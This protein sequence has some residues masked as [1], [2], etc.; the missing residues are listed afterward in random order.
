MHHQLHTLGVSIV[1]ESLD[2]EVRIRCDE[3]EDI[4]LPVVGPVFPTNVPALNE[5]L[6]QAVGGGEVDVLAHLGVVGAVAAVGL[7]L[8]PVYAVEL[9]GGIL[10]GVVP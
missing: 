4:V 5:H 7:S 9:D 6:G 3:I 8:A 2:I 10:I 1:V